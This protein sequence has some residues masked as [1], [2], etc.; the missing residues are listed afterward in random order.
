MLT[1]YLRIAFR[2]LRRNKLYS[3][4]N[5][6]CLAV[7][8]AVSMTIMLYVLHE[9]SFDRWF[10]NA[11]RIYSVSGTLKMGGS[12]INFS[13]VAW[14]TGP[15]V[16][17]ADDNVEGFVRAYAPYGKISIGLPSQPGVRFPEN[18]NF[19]F[20]DSNFFRFFS[21]QLLKGDPSQVLQR[22]NTVV[23]TASAAKKYFGSADA[24]GRLLLFNRTTTL[25]VTGVS[26]DP[27]SNSSISY[28]LVASVRSM[29]TIKEYTAHLKEDQAGPGS[30]MT[31]LLLRKP[32]AAKAVEHTIARLAALRDNADKE[33][34]YPLTALTDGHLHRNFGDFSNLRYLHIFPLIAGLILLLALIN[35]MSLATARAATRAKEVGVRKVMGAGRSRIAGQ[36]Y[37]ESALYVLLSFILGGILFLYLRPWFFQLLQLKIDSS[38]LLTPWVPGCFAGLFLLVVLV[39]GSYPSLVLSAFNPAAVLYGR[40]SKQRAGVNVRKAFTVLQFTISIALII[41]SWVIG[42][43][44]NYIRH[45]DTG[46]DRENVLM[47]PF[48]TTL[49]H[50]SAFKQEVGA[51]PGVRQTATSHYA[52]YKGYDIFTMRPENKPEE[53]PVSVLTVDNDFISLLGL[54]WKQKPAS[55]AAL[56]DG[57]HVLLNESAAGL[58]DMGDDPVNR[59]L[60]SGSE[61]YTVA[62]VLADFNYQSLEHKIGGLA[63]FV[64]SDTAGWGSG[65]NGCLLVKTGAHTNIPSVIAAVKKIYAR[66]DQA[67]AFEYQFMDDAFNSLYKAEDRLAGLFN[68]FTLITVFIACMGLF[69]LATFAAQQRVKEIGIRKVLGDSVMGITARLAKDFLKPVLLAILAA[70]PVAWWAMSKWL[71]GF[72]YRT[73]I[74]AWVFPAVG[75]LVLVVALATVFFQSVGA[76]R[77]NPVDNLRTE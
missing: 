2:N 7:G 71:Q 9:Y 69:A 5:I 54:R 17:K 58:L 42:D 15:M 34:V 26:A 57:K 60:R 11:K 55:K 32:S 51:L 75:A 56:N 24:I 53:I 3:F 64:S 12:R 62:G 39:S 13:Q 65:F 16:Q 1:N 31:W 38:F 37:T 21:F 10:A 43:E 70:I 44:L 4:I 72:A 61:D 14:S 47:V 20:A 22:P 66:H 41:C 27:P 6:S 8:I 18:K 76:A 48:A 35:Y 50:Y 52:M 67:T 45:T 28:D 29:A 23:L 46:V 30:F 33:D 25:E 77:A 59:K 68:V 63:L 19:L 73:P 40:A 36:F 49:Q 74:K